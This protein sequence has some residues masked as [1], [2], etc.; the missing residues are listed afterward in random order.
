MREYADLVRAG[1][2]SEHERLALLE[3][4]SDAVLEQRGQVP[5]SL[6]AIATKIDFY[7]EQI[8]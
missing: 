1:A 4:H 5:R 2:G 6:E 7:R 3:A 8:S